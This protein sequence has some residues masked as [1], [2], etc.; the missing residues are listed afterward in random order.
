MISIVTMAMD[1]HGGRIYYSDMAL[2]S[3]YSIKLQSNKRA[4]PESK[5]VVSG[6]YK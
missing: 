2:G 6:D 5:P 4:V 3:I 1:F